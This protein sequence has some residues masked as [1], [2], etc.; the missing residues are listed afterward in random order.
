MTLRLRRSARVFLFNEADEVLL[1]RFVALREDGP[2]VFWVTP[3]GEMEPEE[4]PLA[5]AERELFEEL[6]LRLPLAGPV[7]Q[8]S[9][10]T[11]VHLGEMVQNHDIFFAAQCE[12]A[13][14]R[15][16]GTTAEEIALMQEIRWWTPAELATTAETIFPARMAAIMDGMRSRWFQ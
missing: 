15:L 3:G 5:A 7:H 11:F 14:P 10:H 12:R 16:L 2:F 13:A 6:G 1:I 4:T 9:G 8:E